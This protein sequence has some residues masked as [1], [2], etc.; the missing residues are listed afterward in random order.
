MSNDNSVGIKP[1]Q[2]QKKNGLGKGEER[3]RKKRDVKECQCV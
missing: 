3:D 2:S 1:E